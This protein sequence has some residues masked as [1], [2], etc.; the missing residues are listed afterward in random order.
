M[1]N[2]IR[3]NILSILISCYFFP[4]RCAQHYMF[5]ATDFFGIKKQEMLL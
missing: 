1:P 4:V 2:V 5:M 3:S